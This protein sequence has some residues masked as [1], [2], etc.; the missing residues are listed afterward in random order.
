MMENID[1]IEFFLGDQ[2][3]EGEEMYGDF[4]AYDVDLRVKFLKF[5][6]RQYNASENNNLWIQF[7][8]SFN[9]TISDVLDNRGWERV[10]DPDQP[11][12]FLW[13]N[14]TDA[15]GLYYKMHLDKGKN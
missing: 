10:N 3:A 6:R 8:C 14:I 7:R 11:W 9:N 1:G 4:D 15:F 12:D 2:D 13:S 5:M